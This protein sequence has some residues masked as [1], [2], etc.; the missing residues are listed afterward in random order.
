MIGCNATSIPLAHLSHS[1]QC[2]VSP[3]QLRS[4]CPDSVR[5]L[6]ARAVD[7]G[8][9]PHQASVHVG[10]NGG[11]GPALSSPPRRA[12]HASVRVAPQA[13][14]APASDPRARKRTDATRAIRGRR[15]VQEG[16]A[17]AWAAQFVRASRRLDTAHAEMGAPRTGSRILNARACAHAWGYG[18]ISGTCHARRCACAPTCSDGGPWGVAGAR[19]FARARP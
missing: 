2:Q 15:H 3:P 18:M 19:D 13:T 5:Q 7:G 16:A 1:A 17:H 8:A 9:P 10:A 4:R 11:E 12:R 14:H 6:A